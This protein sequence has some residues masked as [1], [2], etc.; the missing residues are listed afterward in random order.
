MRIEVNQLMAGMKLEEPIKGPN[1]AVV[2]GA[3]IELT[4]KQIQHLK[5]FRDIYVEVDSKQA[6]ET[7]QAKEEV[8]KTVNQKLVKDTAQSIRELYAQ[9]NNANVEKV[10]NNSKQIVKAIE[11]DEVFNYSL[12]TYEQK[13]LFAHAVRVACF[14]V[15]LA[16]IYNNN[17]KKLY[18][19]IHEEDL[20]NL[21][22]VANAAM[23]HNIGK[24]CEN[25]ETL[26]QIKEIPNKEKL[27]EMFPGIKDT[28]LDKYDKKFTSVYSYCLIEDMHSISDNAKKMVLLSKEP[29]SENGCLKVPFRLSKQKT[30]WMSGAKIIRVCDTFDKLNKIT[31]D[32][33][34]SL[35]EVAM[36][37]AQNA[38]NGSISQEGAQ[39]L[40]DNI[41]LYP[42]STKV[43]LS[44]GQIATVVQHNP[45][46]YGIYKPVVRIIG[47]AKKIDLGEVTDIT[48]VSIVNNKQNLQTL[49]KEQIDIMKKNAIQ[50]NYIH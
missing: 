37:L 6:E 8:E 7:M 21:E 23:F 16:K 30:P 2:L 50:T 15:V 25:K 48:I 41:Q 11:S 36:G 24:T 17:L 13:D 27:Q 18:P 10:K 45:G 42:L 33:G 34:N 38:K 20:I 40:I 43:K 32:N 22:D 9:P 3:G 39:L 44:N 1:G 14:S 29:D 26:S 5:K 47:T 49:S 28:P 4:A 19:N 31:I 46:L 35:E 12:E